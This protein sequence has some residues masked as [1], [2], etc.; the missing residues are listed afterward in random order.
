VPLL[1]ALALAF[2]LAP[3]A[4]ANVTP[5]IVHGTTA[6]IKDFPFQVAV[7]ASAFGQICGGAIIDSTHVITAAHCL[8]DVSSPS[9]ASDPANISVLAGTADLN[10]GGTV[11]QADSVAFDPSYD[12]STNDFDIGVITLHDALPVGAIDGTSTIAPITF[13][14][15][16]DFS[17]DQLLPANAVVTGW[18]DTSPEPPGPVAPSDTLMRA[19]VPLVS[20][21]MCASDYSGVAPITQRMFCAGDHNFGSGITDSCQGDSG[22]P[23]VLDSDQSTPNPPNDYV[24]AGLVDS[25]QGCAQAGFPGI[26]DRMSNIALQSFATTAHPQAPRR[27]SPTTISGGNAPG[28]TLTCSSGGWSDNSASLTYQFFRQSSGAAL[29]SA[30]PTTTYT[31]QASDIGSRILCEVQATNDGGYGFSDSA[32][33]FIPIPAPPAPP[34]TPP[35]AKDTTAPRLR[36]GSKKCTKTS[37]TLKVTVTDPGSPSSG[38]GKVKATLGFSRKVKCRSRG[39]SAARTCSKHVTRALKVSGGAG[40]KFTIVA[41][42][43]TPGKGYT[44]SIVPFDQAGNRPQFSTIT[45][46]RT[47]PRHQ[48]GLF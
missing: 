37:C 1:A 24:L 22:G 27:T 46:V 19:T 32:G 14:N 16:T 10:S 34:V 7:F 42:H 3:V 15:E 44:I 36:V 48:R 38:V 25:G 17:A 31:I 13:I 11:D 4:R 6:D 28:Q 9:E 33:V 35:T 40:G 18:G 47:K 45:S 29:T 2:A 41:N 5:K 8:F 26:Y 12:P 30:S 39:A 23:I 43:L 20:D 21:S